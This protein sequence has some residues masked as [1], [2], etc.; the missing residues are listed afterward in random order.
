MKTEAIVTAK[1]LR[2]LNNTGVI[3]FMMSIGNEDRDFPHA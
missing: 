2:I 1:L 3:P